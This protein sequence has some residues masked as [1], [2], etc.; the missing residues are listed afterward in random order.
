VAKLSLQP[1]EPPDAPGETRNKQVSDSAPSAAEA[2]SIAPSVA[3]MPPSA[4]PSPSSGT[5]HASLLAARW[6]A[7]L[8][9]AGL[10]PPVVDA[11]SLGRTADAVLGLRSPNAELANL[12]RAAQNPQPARAA[13]TFVGGWA[14]DIGQC[15]THKKTPLVISSSA[16]KNENGEC[17]FGSV[18][19]VAENRWRVAAICTADGQFWRAHIAL[20]LV[21]P[22]LTWSS[23]RGTTTYVRCKR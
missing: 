8:D 5:D 14:D 20:K 4:P 2:R 7:E 16:A 1:P 19:R 6:P 10:K 15:R 18:A 23:E 3:T 22:N 21:E 13:P 17:D 9:A 11:G 12:K